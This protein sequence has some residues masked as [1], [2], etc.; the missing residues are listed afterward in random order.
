MASESRPASHPLIDRLRE[1]PTEFDLLWALRCLECVF[2]ESPRIGHAVRASDEPYRFGQTPSLAFAPATLAPAAPGRPG[3][4][5]GDLLRLR[6]FYP[7]LLGPNGPLPL[8]VTEYIHDRE[9]N[10]ADPTLAHFLDIFHHRIVSLFY[11]AWASSQQPAAHQRVGK[12]GGKLISNDRFALYTASLIGLGA[13][14]F[15]NRDAVPDAAKL[16]YSGHLSCQT[17]HAEGLASI[18]AEYFDLPAQVEQFVGQWLA[19]DRPRQLQLGKSRATGTLGSTAIVGA[20]IWD[21]QQKFRLR[22]GPMEYTEYERLLPGGPHLPQLVSWV[23]SYIGDELSFDVRLILKA[24]QVPQ[25]CLGRIGRLGWSS[26]VGSK[27]H[28][29]DAGD[30]ILRPAV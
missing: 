9:H 1:N 23:K 3:S 26:W 16:Y 2:E 10:N 24:A 14:S 13:P 17:R 30:L 20:S 4:S 6:V 11:R 15:E 5:R 8:H 29:Q 12:S 18:I 27:A 28:G 19:L 22:L 7:G 21:R 25:A